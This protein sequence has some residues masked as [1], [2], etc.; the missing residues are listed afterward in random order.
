MWLLRTVWIALLLPCTFASQAGSFAVE[1]NGLRCVASA[2]LNGASVLYMS[3]IEGAVSCHTLDGKTL[4]RNPTATPAVMF[5]IEA[6]DI[7]GDGNDEL[8]TASGDGHITCWGSDGKQ[9][10]RFHPGHKARF[11]ELAVVEDRIFAGGNDHVL[12]EISAKG[13]LVSETPIKGVVRKIEA[14]NFLDPKKPSLLVMTY[15]HD[16][17]GWQFCGILDPDTKQVLSTFDKDDAPSEMKNRFML[18]GMDVADLDGDGRDDLLFFGAG[19]QPAFVGLNGRFEKIAGFQGPEKHRQRYAHTIGACLLPVRKEVMIQFGGMRYVLDLT[20]KL[21]HTVGKPHRGIIVNDYTVDAKSKRLIGAGE[22]AGGNGVYH[23]DLDK[24]DWWKTEHAPTG[25]MVEVEQNIETLYEQALEFKMPDYQQK[26]DEPWVMITSLRANEEVN[27]LKGAELQ[28]VQQYT[29]HEKFDRSH[30]VKAIGP[31]ALKQDRRG[32]YTWS[33]VDILAAVSEFEAQGAPFALW[34]GHGNDPWYVPIDTMEKVL[35]AAPTTCYGFIYA[36]MAN[37]E[38]VRFQYFIDN[39]IP[40]LAKACRKQGKAKLYFRYKNVFWAA[41]SHQEP[42]KRLFFSGKYSD[43]LVPSSEDTNSRMQDVNFS[44]RVG[45]LSAGY[46]DDMAM[47]L[48][49]DNPACWRPLSPCGQRTVSPYLRNGALLASYGARYGILFPIAYLEEPGMNVLFALMKS[50]ALP[51]VDREDILSVGSWHLIQDLDEEL[52]HSIEGGHEIDK[53]TPHDEDAVL[54]V[55]QIQ[56]SGA[57]IL[58][59]D[60]SKQA[61]GVDYRWLNFVPEMPRGMV[62][63]APIEHRAALDKQGVLYTVSDCKVGYIDGEPVPAKAFGST[64]GSTARKGAARL[65]V[66]VSGASWSALRI[67]KN[68]TRVLLADQGYIT[69]QEREATIRLQGKQPKRARDILSGESLTISG[70]AIQ[71]TVPAGSIRLIDLEY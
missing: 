14:G 50:G 30:L 42:W 54:S 22:V 6:A 58:D 65:P 36:E 63:I 48:V 34:T 8:L 2:R 37:P 21:L 53:Y 43:I 60:Y 52:I 12:Y 49:D 69:P 40:R 57:N 62:P 70:R 17:F 32:K 67:D 19:I 9:R 51:V 56:W 1:G 44:G 11:S 5:E 29:W 24:E 47:R 27:R 33:Q 16:K 18:T 61:M 71:L 64:I 41:T 28:F 10:W 68:H 7:D 25:R 35:E 66:V 4:W 46:I 20:G 15:A 3:E 59:H 55:A 45:M 31:D 39:Y 38:D 23:Y 13:K 26:S